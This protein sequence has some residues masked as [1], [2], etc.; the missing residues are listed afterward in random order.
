[1]AILILI[2]FGSV[3][4]VLVTIVAVQ[5]SMSLGRWIWKNAFFLLMVIAFV[6]F[7][8]GSGTG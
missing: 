4:G 1:M 7:S 8:L 6:V 5:S 2:L 3:V